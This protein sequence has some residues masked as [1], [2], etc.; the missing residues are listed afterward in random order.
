MYHA[1]LPSNWASTH[2]DVVYTLKELYTG[3][4]VLYIQYSSPVGRAV[5]THLADSEP[6]HVLTAAA[7][8]HSLSHLLT[9]S[10]SER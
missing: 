10:P 1:H 9:L 2:S 3:G 4:A 8:L 5:V 7:L 6:H